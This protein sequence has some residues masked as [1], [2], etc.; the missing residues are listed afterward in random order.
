MFG[1]IPLTQRLQERTCG[2]WV[3]NITNGETVAFLRFE[4]AVQEIFSVQV[5]PGIRFP[6]IIDW[7]E[8]LI[9]QSYILPDD[10]LAEVPEDL[11]DNKT[12]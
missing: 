5:L 8:Q 7:D 10:A 11:L 4:G 9:G 3:I 1:S 6:E 12:S 2:I